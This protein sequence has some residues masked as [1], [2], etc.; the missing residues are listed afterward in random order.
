M[1]VRLPDIV[2]VR[3]V[4]TTYVMCGPLPPRAE[5]GAHVAL[6]EPALRKTLSAMP[7]FA[8]TPNPI[9]Q[10]SG[11]EVCDSGPLSGSPLSDRETG[12]VAGEARARPGSVRQQSDRGAHD[13]ETPDL[14]PTKVHETRHRIPAVDAA[15]GIAL[16][17]MVMI[18]V[19][20]VRTD[21][22]LDRLW[23][24]PFGRASILF[25]VLAGVGMSMFF[26]SRSRDAR[27][28]PVLAWR[29]LIFVVGGLSLQLLTPA[30][31]VI[32]PTYGA[33]FLGALLWRR[34]PDRLLLALA[35]VML[36]VGPALFQAHQNPIQHENRMP[37][38]TDSL[39]PLLHSL[40]LS[41]PYPLVVW[42]V[43]FLVGMW[44]GRQDLRDAAVHR[45]ML[46][47]GGAAAVIGFGISQTSEAFLG[48]QADAGW[49]R[50]LTGAAHG[51]MPLWLV[52]SVGSAAFV[53]GALMLFWPK[54]P[55]WFHPLTAV[56]ELAFTLYVLH[57][58]AI[59]AMGGRIDDRLLGVAVTVALLG[60]FTAA[61][62]FWVRRY[63]SGPL[64]RLLR[65]RWLT[66][67]V[68]GVA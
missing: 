19:G 68:R 42:V 25:V 3:A 62:T 45:R 44:I 20:V 2:A 11:T 41:G 34:L 31:S 61:A 22:W 13:A 16:F 10:A 30:V 38:L 48:T 52:S 67:T 21:G 9:P 37:T 36:V 6:L 1:A 51:Q 32:L 43:P 15:R 54:V 14:L 57:F 63:G 17:G 23:T 46:V 27:R 59:A 40:V 47:W 24:I 26:T 12:V 29:A 66:G 5:L 65:A 64:E 60:I 49:T 35:G 8:R 58:F 53:I 18:N 50:L 39:G 56:G 4:C 55:R 33:M 7:L 28:W